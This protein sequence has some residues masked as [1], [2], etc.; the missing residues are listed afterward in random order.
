MPVMGFIPNYWLSSHNL[1]LGQ[2]LTSPYVVMEV[3]IIILGAPF[4]EEILFRG[5]PCSAASDTEGKIRPRW[6]LFVILG[7]SFIFFGLAHGQGYFSVLLQGVG[8]LL[9]ARL[10]FRNGPNTVASYFSGVAA[11]ALYNISVVAVTWIWLS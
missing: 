7:F 9:L 11:H 3:L 8:G 10:F 5:L 4:L 6:G 1:T 2:A